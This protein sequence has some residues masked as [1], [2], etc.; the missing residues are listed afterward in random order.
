MTPYS[1]DVERWIDGG[2]PELDEL[3]LIALAAL[4]VLELIDAIRRPR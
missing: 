3:P 2:A 4:A 1:G